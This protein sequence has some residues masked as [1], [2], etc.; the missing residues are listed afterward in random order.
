MLNP[1]RR[2]WERRATTAETEERARL[3]NTRVLKRRNQKHFTR[4][5][6]GAERRKKGEMEPILVMS[7]SQG[8]WGGRG[9]RTGGGEGER[10]VYWLL[11]Y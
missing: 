2:V 1:S 9:G 4:I 7:T 3:G 8:Y 6:G 10:G 5:L 11:V